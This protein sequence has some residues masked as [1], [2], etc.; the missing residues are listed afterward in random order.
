MNKIKIRNPLLG[1]YLIYIFFVLGCEAADVIC[2]AFGWRQ[3]SVGS[4]ILVLLVYIF[5][6]YK[7]SP[8]IE[9]KKGWDK[10]DWKKFIGIFVILVLGLTK[11]VYPDT[12]SDTLRYHL[13]AQNPEFINYFQEHFAKG[14]FQVWGFR[15][16]DKLFYVF[17]Y[18]LGYRYGTLLN[19][20]VLILI[21]LQ[22]YD[23]LSEVDKK[24]G[25]Q[26][27]DII[28]YIGTNKIVWSLL[29][30]L[31]QDAIFMIGL[32]Y[33]DILAIPVA[34]EIVSQ[35]MKA[36]T[37][38]QKPINIIYYAALNGVWFAFKMTNIIYIIP[39]VLIY[40]YYVR[41]S[42]DVKCL[43]KSALAAALPC[44]IYLLYN[45]ISTGNPIF[46]YFNVLFKSDFFSNANFKDGRWGGENL[47]QQ[48]FWFVYLIFKPDYRQEELSWKYN[49]ILIVGFIGLVLICIT[50]AAQCI[51]KNKIDRSLGVYML[52][53]FSSS[54]LYGL[55]TGY[56]RY[57]IFGMILLG[58]CAY[59]LILKIDKYKIFRM[60]N[61]VISVLLVGCLAMTIKD[62][63][64]GREYSFNTWTWD[65]FRQQASQVFKDS[66]N[67]RHGIPNDLSIDMFY[68]TDSYYDSVTELYDKDIYM[69]QAEYQDAVQNKEIVDKE[70]QDHR[71]L[72]EGNVYDIKMRN[73][74]FIDEYAEKYNGFGMYIDDL[75]VSKNDI[76][77][78]VLI[79]LKESEKTNTVFFS[80]KN[81]E[82]ECNEN[83]NAKLNLICGRIYGWTHMEECDLVIK[84]VNG[85]ISE[86]VYREKMKND[87][88]G[89]YTIPLGMIDSNTKIVIEIQ[90]SMGNQ[91]GSDLGDNYFIINPEIE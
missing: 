5:V 70:I 69:F 25:R 76:G 50:L 67:T 72:F 15:L 58:G 81:I 21:Y 51:K 8:Y 88:M 24:Y 85:V 54:I 83:K 47:F 17:R 2:Y 66:G 52:V 45:Y 30:T 87:Y 14:N 56:S 46:P 32:Y 60:G 55:T 74:Y 38:E 13:T 64:S 75:K 20:I 82:L 80:G 39:C 42:M 26:E 53:F 91:I 44:S 73:F 22:I 4:R 68:I 79:K 40:I 37:E 57:F 19:V 61:M 1:V 28:S 49:G 62:F 86:E 36:G 29:L 48:I 90:D 84:K 27:K 7:L 71:Q 65:S 33:V 9:I 3:V 78:Y 77:E 23:I 63:Y 12:A 10:T 6:L 18:L 43:G 34:I 31:I 16:G 11:S 41:K 59:Y 89:K 35:L